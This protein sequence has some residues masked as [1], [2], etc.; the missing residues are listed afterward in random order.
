MKCCDGC[1]TYFD[2]GCAYTKYNGT[3]ECP[4]TPCVIKIMCEKIC[5]PFRD[6]MNDVAVKGFKPTGA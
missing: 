5:D 3:G 4:C 6:Y 2:G 1:L